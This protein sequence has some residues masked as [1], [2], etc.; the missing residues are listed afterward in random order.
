MPDIHEQARETATRWLSA[1]PGEFPDQDARSIDVLA[2]AYL[3]LAAHHPASALSCSDD[4]HN[5][6]VRLA[7]RDAT[8]ARQARELARLN[9][10][11]DPRQRY[12][13][14]VDGGYPKKA[15]VLL[16]DAGGPREFPN[17]QAARS[18]VRN[19]ALGYLEPKYL[20]IQEES[21]TP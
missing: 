16:H 14:E 10:A 13:V 20:P 19:H 5:A 8:I 3:D 12:H 6:R 21:R 4:L 7:E 9:S 11:R 18:F 2:F 1:K 17:K 15:R